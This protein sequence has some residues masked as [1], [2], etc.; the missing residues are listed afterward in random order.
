MYYDNIILKYLPAFYIVMNNKQECTNDLI[1]QT[2]IKFINMGFN[3]IKNFKTITTNDELA[4]INIVKKYFP[5]TNRISC[6]F[7]L[8]NNLEKKARILG[9]K[10]LKY[11]NINK[12]VINCFGML[13][14][15]FNGN[16]D[17]LNIVYLT[18][19]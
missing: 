5:C 17:D 15:I 11:K 3:E 9:L 18:I 1:F 12:I 8:K 10:K 2:V 6:W 13:P 7:H 16:I 19:I 4:L 14:L